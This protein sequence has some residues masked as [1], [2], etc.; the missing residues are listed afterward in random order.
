MKGDNM[1]IA[2]GQGTIRFESD[3]EMDFQDIIRFFM[4]IAKDEDID[5]VKYFVDGKPINLK[6]PPEEAINKISRIKV[7]ELR[8]NCRY[9]SEKIYF[10]AEVKEKSRLKLVMD[11]D[12]NYLSNDLKKIINKYMQLRK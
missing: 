8:M 4:N 3:D 7:H 6:D 12:L 11:E 2:I 1:R 10:T 9:I 5:H